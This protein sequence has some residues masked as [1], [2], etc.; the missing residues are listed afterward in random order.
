MG[1]GIKLSALTPCVGVELSSCDGRVELPVAKHGGEWAGG[2][3][4]LLSGIPE[5]LPSATNAGLYFC[6]SRP[7]LAVIPSTVADIR[8]R[9][10]RCLEKIGVRRSV[11]SRAS[12]LLYWSRWLVRSTANLNTVWRRLSV[13]SAADLFVL[14]PASTLSEEDGLY[15]LELVSGIEMT[16]AL[17]RGDHLPFLE[18]G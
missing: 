6:S 12:L 9:C 3:P 2:Q 16:S 13:H 18:P 17:V 15:I 14:E 11:Y 5:R 8:I 10:L 7:H 1:R 4:G